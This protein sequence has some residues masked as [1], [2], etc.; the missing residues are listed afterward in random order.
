[1]VVDVIWKK[2]GEKELKPSDIDHEVSEHIDSSGRKYY[3]YVLNRYRMAPDSEGLIV[4][5]RTLKNTYYNGQKVDAALTEIGE[6]AFRNR[7]TDAVKIKGYG[8]SGD[9][10]IKIGREAFAGDMN[11]FRFEAIDNTDIRFAKIGESAF[12]GSYAFHNMRIRSRDERYEG[13]TIGKKAFDGTALDLSKGDDVEFK[14]NWHTIGEGAFED[15]SLRYF[16]LNKI[17]GLKRIGR[18]AFSYTRIG[19]ELPGAEAHSVEIPAGVESIGESAFLNSGIEKLKFQGTSLRSIGDYAFGSNQLAELTLPNGITGIGKGAFSYN[20]LTTADIS[21]T[22]V[23]EVAEGA[24][25]DNQLTDVTLP[26]SNLTDRKS[27]V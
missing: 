8:N 2:Y 1:M 23:T 9:I 5:P 4:I 6:R 12:E 11:L 27:V 21:K 24:F 14:G 22:A 25:R 26:G 18:R 13:G 20:K 16:R 15:A 19:K 3:T 7:Y 10:P 17:E